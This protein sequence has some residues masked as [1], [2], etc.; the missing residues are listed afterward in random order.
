MSPK[1]AT[2]GI[3]AIPSCVGASGKL[4]HYSGVQRPGARELVALGLVLGVVG[5]AFGP[6]TSRVGMPSGDHVDFY[7]RVAQYDVELREG[8]WPQLLPDAVRG[9]GHAFPR[10]YPPLAQFAAVAVYQAVPDIVLASHLAMFAGVLL[11][12]ATMYVLLLAITG[13]ALPSVLGSLVYCLSPYRATQLYVRGSFA[14]GWALAWYPLVM[15]GLWQWVRLRRLPAWWPLA[16]AAAILSHTATSLWALPALGVVTLL[17]ST[18]K[19]TGAAW[20]ELRNSGTLALGLTACTLLPVAW[21]L[22]GVRAGSPD[23]MAATPQA[24]G[25]A[26][27]TWRHPWA[28]A[29]AEVIIAAGAVVLVRS[30][31]VER[32]GLIMRLAGWSLLGQVAL[33][34]M[35]AAPAGAWSLVPQPWRYVQFGWRLMG[36]ATLFAALGLG[37]LA[38]RFTTRFGRVAVLVATGLVALGGLLKLRTAGVHDPSLVHSSILPWTGQPYGD[39]GLTRDGDYLPR[40][41]PPMTLGATISRTRDSLIAAGALRLDE[42]GRPLAVRVTNQAGDVPLPLVAYDLFRVEDQNGKTLP[43]RSEQGQLV[44][45]VTAS[46]SEVRVRRHLPPVV[47]VGLA[48]SGLSL[49][50]VV[51]GAMRAASQK[52][53][54]SSP[55]VL[56][57]SLHRTPEIRD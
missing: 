14:E 53:A 25:D 13:R 50:I 6:L 47:A 17:I 35:S 31:R 40:D 21:Y 22:S 23:L 49:L 18:E 27:A 56:L 44:V 57:P 54:A 52:A 9:G 5:V 46:V 48:I 43:V 2:P 51:F 7:L 3:R 19:P 8:H 55:S 38:T 11:S 33:V 10:F 45:A 20:R 24:I 29:A 12:A 39:L 16:V 1:I 26:A 28:M 15:L 36:P 34:A 41:A 42:H 30:G 32:G 37:L 4:R